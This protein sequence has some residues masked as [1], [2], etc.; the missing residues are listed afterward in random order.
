MLTP[1]MYPSQ[2]IGMDFSHLEDYTAGVLA[3]VAIDGTAV[4]QHTWIMGRGMG[5]SFGMHDMIDWTRYKPTRSTWNRH[6]KAKAQP[7]RGPRGNNPW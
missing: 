5:K 2:I 3:K 4:I 6:H 1:G 7:N